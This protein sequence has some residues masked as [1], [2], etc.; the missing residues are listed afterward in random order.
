[1]DL[2]PCGISEKGAGQEEDRRG[3]GA[4]GGLCLTFALYLF[5]MSGGV[6]AVVGRVHQGHVGAAVHVQ[7]LLHAVDAAAL[8][9]GAE[10]GAGHRVVAAQTVH[11][12]TGRLAVLHATNTTRIL[13]C[14]TP[15]AHVL[16]T[17]DGQIR[18][19]LPPELEDNQRVFLLLSHCSLDTDTS[20]ISKYDTFVKILRFLQ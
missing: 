5:D 6:Q 3:K 2:R 13:S 7:H 1:M 18:F 15:G 16:T 14:L 8:A 4:Y 10:G 17:C 9:A 19:T 12:A 20:T 11:L